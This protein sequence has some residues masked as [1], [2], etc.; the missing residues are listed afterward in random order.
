MNNTLLKVLIVDDDEITCFL[1]RSILVE[2][3][4]VDTILCLPDGAQALEYLK[5]AYLSE[6]AGN[7][8]CPDIIFLDI[9]MPILNSFELLEEVQNLPGIDMRKLFVVLMTSSMD[10]RDKARAANYQVDYF[11]FK[12]LTSENAL[13]VIKAYQHK[14]CPKV[15]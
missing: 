15:H 9:N 10:E 8:F 7:G 1:N 2:Q 14:C 6:G 11:L 3:P 5:T 12:P 13:E 4:F